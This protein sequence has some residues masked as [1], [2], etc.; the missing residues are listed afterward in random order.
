MAKFIT[1]CSSSGGNSEYIES[2]GSAVLIDAGL[3]CKQ[4]CLALDYFG[5]DEKKIE[6]I[7]VTHEHSD[8]AC[9]V[10]VFA[11]KYS[12]PV[13]ATRG[14]IE[15]MKEKNYLSDKVDYRTISKNGAELSSM[16]VKSFPTSHDTYESCGFT[17]ETGGETKISILTD[18]GIVTRQMFDS[19]KG[20]DLVLLESNHDVKMLR[21][22]PYPQSL[23]DRICSRLGHLSNDD[24]AKVAAGLV[25]T[26]TSRIVLAHLSEHNNTPEKAFNTTNNALL[27]RGFSNSDYILTVAPHGR[28]EEIIYL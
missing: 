2:D 4:L 15:G 13:Y 24:S 17:I 12:I 11:S 5:I 22:G 6:A 25:E 14:T 26:G 21:Y 28:A 3:N 10:K 18:T 9:G 7:F 27:R 8:H 23:K 19:V 16:I 20:S 1:L